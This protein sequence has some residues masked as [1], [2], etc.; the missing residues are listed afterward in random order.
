MLRSFELGIFYMLSTAHDDLNLLVYLFVFAVEVRLLD[1]SDG[2]LCIILWQI[3]IL[4]Y[5]ILPRLCFILKVLI[6]SILF[7]CVDSCRW[8][9]AANGRFVDHL[10]LTGI[11][12]RLINL[13]WLHLVLLLFLLLYI[14]CWHVRR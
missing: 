3:S 13:Q 7:L 12:Q 9:S 5:F 2:A 6:K 8:Y 1:R 10:R 11:H 14:F 4:V